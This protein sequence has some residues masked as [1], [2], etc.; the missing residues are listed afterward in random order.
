MSTFIVL[1]EWNRENQRDVL[2]HWRTEGGTSRW[3]AAAVWTWWDFTE[4][5]TPNGSKLRSVLK[6]NQSNQITLC[7]F[8]SLNANRNRVKLTRLNWWKPELCVKYLLHTHMHT[9]TRT[10][11]CP[12][13]SGVRHHG[14]RQT[15]DQS[16]LQKAE[17]SASTWCGQKCVLQQMFYSSA[18]SL[19]TINDL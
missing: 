10:H 17:C 18:E 12:L 5:R 4:C 3:T 16:D 15:N 2:N 7:I 14:N 9:H 13:S 8:N 11:T 6:L 19:N 1:I